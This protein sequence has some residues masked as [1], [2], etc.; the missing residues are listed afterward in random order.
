MCGFLDFWKKQWSPH[1]YRIKSVT[2]LE[3][4][5]ISEMFHFK[6]LKKKPMMYNASEY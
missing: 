3:Q 2:F 5:F 1:I 6:L 4:G